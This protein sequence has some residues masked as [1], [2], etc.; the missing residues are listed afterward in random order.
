MHAL[1][2][3][4]RNPPRGQPS[5]LRGALLVGRL[6][7]VLALGLPLATVGALVA[8]WPATLWSALADMGVAPTRLVQTGPRL[9]LAFLL[10]LLPV[11]CMSAALL[12]AR[13]CMQT[14]ARG[15]HFSVAAAEALRGFASLA[16]AAGLAGLLVPP[17][18][19]LLLTVGGNGQAALVFSAGSQQLL[20]LLFAGIVRLMAAVLR[21]A[22]ALADEHRQIV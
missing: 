12:Q 17:A 8:G 3:P 22:A 5:P 4:S 21:E 19:G 16:F 9:A 1:F 6:C 2:W 10:A 20:W 13:R 11:L 18:T 7:G 15:D 14:F